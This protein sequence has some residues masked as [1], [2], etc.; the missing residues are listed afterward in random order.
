MRVDGEMRKVMIHANKNG[1]LYVI[2]RTNGKLIA[3]HPFVKVNWATHIDLEDRPA[4]ADRCLRR[5]DHGR[6]GRDLAVARHQRGAD[7]L[8]SEDRAGLPELVGNLPRIMKFVQ[9]EFVLGAELHR[10]RDQLPHSSSR[11]AV[12]YHIAM[13]PLTG[14]KKWK[15]P[16][17]ELPSSAGML[18]TDGGLCSP[19][20]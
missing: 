1:F 12:G 9:V 6:R 8:Q 11:R 20:S 10:R 5:A 2:D 4:G 7:R 19:A 16:L 17:T 14:K 13:N 15:V 18:A 3:A